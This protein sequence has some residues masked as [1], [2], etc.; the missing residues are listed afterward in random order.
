[1]IELI[2]VIVILGILAV[3]AIPKMA[4]TRNDARIAATS[5]SIATAATEIASYAISQGVVET[6]MSKMSQVIQTLIGRG[7]ATQPDMNVTIV[8]FKMGGINDCIALE[9]DDGGMDANL[10]VSYPGVFG[11]PSCDRLRDRFDASHYPIPLRGAR[12]VH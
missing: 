12:V 4:A 6:D 3:I 9:V 8:N 7:D 11:D 1:M 2:F 10:T 5:Q